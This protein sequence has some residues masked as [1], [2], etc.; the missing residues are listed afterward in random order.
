MKAAW[1]PPA[2]SHPVRNCRYK[3]LKDQLIKAVKSF[4]LNQ[5][6]IEQLVE[7]L[8]DINKRLVQE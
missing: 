5:N 6:R 1:L 3:E 2:N 8:Y 7:Q 4:S